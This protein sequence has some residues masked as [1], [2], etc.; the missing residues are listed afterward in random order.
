MGTKA[1]DIPG[2]HLWWNKD[3]TFP[4]DLQVVCPPSMHIWIPPKQHLK[5]ATE[6]PDYRVGIVIGNWCIILSRLGMRKTKTG[7]TWVIICTLLLVYKE[8]GCQWTGRMKCELSIWRSRTLLLPA[9]IHAFT[10]TISQSPP[11]LLT[12]RTKKNSV[13]YRAVCMTDSTIDLKRFIFSLESSPTENKH[14]HMWN[15]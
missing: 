12:I 13:F 5:R 15:Q 8:G 9:L 4:E 6:R 1:E 11:Q 2:A 10:R 3:C 7:S 14:K